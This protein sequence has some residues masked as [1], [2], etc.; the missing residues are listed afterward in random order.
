MVMDNTWLN[1]DGLYVKFGKTEGVS[2]TQGGFVCRYGPFL[3]YWLTLD[4]TTLDANE[5]IQNDVLVIPKNATILSVTTIA[6][7]GAATGTAID[8]GLIAN[9]R[10]T[11]NADFTADPNGLLAAAPTANMNTDG[12]ISVYQV[13]VTIPTGL[14]GTGALVGTIIPVPTLITASRTDA[15]AFTAGSI[16]TC[17]RVI[18]ESLVGYDQVHVG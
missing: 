15:T 9:D 17:V 18:P 1:S 14:T 16:L 8:V 3:D 11:A 5:N 2:R 10:D 12:E 7:D 13:A 6:V 4:L